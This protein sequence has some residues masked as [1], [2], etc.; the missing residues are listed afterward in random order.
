MC[1][2]PKKYKLGNVQNNK[3]MLLFNSNRTELS[4]SPFLVYFINNW[5]W[6]RGESLTERG[7]TD[8][9]KKVALGA[10]FRHLH[11]FTHMKF[12]KS[13]PA[14]SSHILQYERN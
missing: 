11:I 6:G 1:K 5:I 13:F 2:V 10:S 12:L 3:G 4:D 8:C 9:F 7:C 14:S